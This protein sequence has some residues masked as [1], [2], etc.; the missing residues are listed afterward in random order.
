[1]ET[2]FKKNGKKE[3]TKTYH[4]TRAQGDRRVD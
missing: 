3:D 1:M 2:A 4:S